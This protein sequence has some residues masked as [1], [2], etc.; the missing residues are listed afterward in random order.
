MDP[1]LSLT[2]KQTHKHADTQLYVL[3]HKTLDGPSF[4]YRYIS[5]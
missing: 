4:T 2:N 3:V 5:Q 1:S